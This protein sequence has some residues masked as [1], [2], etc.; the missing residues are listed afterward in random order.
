MSQAVKK[1]RTRFGYY[2]NQKMAEALTEYMSE[3]GLKVRYIHSDVDTLERIE[4][5]RDLRLGTFDVLIG[6]NLLREG[7]DIPEFI[8]WPFLMLTKRAICVQKPRS[9]NHW[10]A[11]RNL[12]GMAILYADRM[13]KSMQAALEESNRRRSKQE[14]FNKE[15]GLTPASIQKRIQDIG[16]QIYSGKGKRKAKQDKILTP[17]QAEKELRNC[18]SKCS[19]PPAIL[20]SNKPPLSAIKSKKLTKILKV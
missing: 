20:I 7:L 5:I 8:W 14:S 12:S 2:S 10:P 13:T 15:N 1:T 3:A 9:S 4:I 6:I 18:A 17:K 11:A 16:G 19:K